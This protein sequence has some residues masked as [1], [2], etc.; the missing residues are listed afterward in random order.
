ML[1]P[2]TAALLSQLGFDAALVERLMF[3]MMVLTVLTVAAAIPTA[4]IARKKGR[5]RSFWLLF[6]LSIPLLPLLLIWWLPAVNPEQPPP[7]S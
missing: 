6:A 5:S 1:D 2:Q 4:I 3:G 7:Q